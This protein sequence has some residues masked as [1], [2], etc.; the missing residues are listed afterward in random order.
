MLPGFLFA[1]PSV[2]DSRFYQEHFRADQQADQH[3]AFPHAVSY[4]HDGIE[5]VVI[6][7]VHHFPVPVL[8]FTSIDG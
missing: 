4:D 2:D 7:P 3:G 5:Q 6:E 1:D 8:A